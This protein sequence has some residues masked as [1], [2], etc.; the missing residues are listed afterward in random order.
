[1]ECRI[2]VWPSSTVVFDAL[3]MLS[4]T[5]NGHV[6]AEEMG[7]DMA[8]KNVGSVGGGLEVASLLLT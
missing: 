7:A 8:D 4:V 2:T 3:F 5:Q 1:M 6:K